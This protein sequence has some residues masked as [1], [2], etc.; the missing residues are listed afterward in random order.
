[1]GTN[2][3]GSGVNPREEERARQIR[4]SASNCGEAAANGGGKTGSQ[5]ENPD[6]GQRI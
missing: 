1:V 2:R 5:T 4:L 3:V 6:L